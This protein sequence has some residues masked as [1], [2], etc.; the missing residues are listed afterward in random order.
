VKTAAIFWVAKIVYHGF[1]ATKN[2]SAMIFAKGK[3]F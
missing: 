2:V 1:V 3:I